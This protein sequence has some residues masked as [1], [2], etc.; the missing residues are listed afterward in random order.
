MEEL[1]ECLSFAWQG[2]KKNRWTADEWSRDSECRKLK[3]ST[4]S[5]NA[6]LTGNRQ[7]DSSK[8]YKLIAVDLDHKNNWDDVV[9]Y[10]VSLQLPE[11]LTAAT[12]SGGA[13]MFFWVNKYI[14]V[15]S[16]YDDRHI[17]GFELKGDNNNITAPGSVFKC[18]AEYKIIKNLPIAKLSSMDVVRLVRNVY[19]RQPVHY[20][21]KKDAKSAHE[22]AVA[23]DPQAKENSR[24]YALRCPFHEDKRASAIMFNSGYFFCSGC[25][26]KEKIF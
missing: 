21:G 12:P 5:A 9:E 25:G 4:A 20:T 23:H 22:W 7:I 26:K 16:I 2:T 18:G 10:Y 24:G 13:H 11:T 14:R 3:D 19:P 17:K 8:T 6:V 15:Q 1:Q